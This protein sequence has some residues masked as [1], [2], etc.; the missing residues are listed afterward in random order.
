MFI[1]SIAHNMFLRG[2]IHAVLNLVLYKRYIDDY[3]G[4]TSSSRE[5]LNQFTTLVNSF[6]PALK[7]TWEISENSFAF[8]DSFSKKRGYPDSAVTTG[9]HSAQEIDRETAL[10]IPFTLTYYPQSLAVEDVTSLKNFKILRNDPET[11]LIFPLYH[12][13]HSNATKTQGTS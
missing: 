11:K 12:S 3:V 4:A 8:F 1:A 10:Q 9:K 2:Q 13:F 5:E 7:Y 6:H